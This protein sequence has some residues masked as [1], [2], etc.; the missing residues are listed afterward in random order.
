M[1]LVV[2]EQREVEFYGDE[3]T[4]VRA[5]DGH[6]YVSVR[7]LCDALGLDRAAQVRRIK[8]QAILLDAYQGGA[9]L[10]S[11]SMQGTG[12]GRQQLGMMR[13]DVVPLFLTGISVNSVYELGIRN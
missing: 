11:P 12:G 13:V 6:I 8:R 3:L 10:T 7:H 5:A 1:S 4:A 9:I 2:I